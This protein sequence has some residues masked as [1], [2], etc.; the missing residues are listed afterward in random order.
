MMNPAWQVGD[1]VRIIEDPTSFI[2]GDD[3]NGLTGMIIGYE[4]EIYTILISGGTRTI[5]VLDFMLSRVDGD[6]KSNRGRI[7]QRGSIV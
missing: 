1:L 4:D 5:R 2:I 3:I 7:S 6:R